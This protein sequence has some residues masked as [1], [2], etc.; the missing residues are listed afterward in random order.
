MYN[1]INVNINSIEK[2]KSFVRD[3][4]SFSCDIDVVCGRYTLN[5]KSIM[6]IFSIDLT[7]ELKV[8]IHSDD[9]SE[10]LR[11]YVA[12]VRRRGCRHRN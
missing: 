10:I 4:E 11:F 9:R 1:E 3:A 2:V 6:G 12:V 5:A 7:K 8:V